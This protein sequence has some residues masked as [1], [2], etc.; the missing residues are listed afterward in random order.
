LQQ[1][2]EPSP[3][4]SGEKEGYMPDNFYL[5]FYEFI[6]LFRKGTHV[7]I[8]VDADEILFTGSYEKCL[9]EKELMKIGYLE[10]L[11]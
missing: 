5:G 3:A 6:I 4:A 8:D 10:S 2:S 1:N 9:K 7:I 11:F